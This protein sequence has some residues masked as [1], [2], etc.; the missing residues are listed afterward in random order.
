MI[1]ARNVGEAARGALTLPKRSSAVPV[2]DQWLSRDE[3]LSQLAACCE[4]ESVQLQRIPDNLLVQLN[5]LSG[6]WQK[7]FRLKSGL[8]YGKIH[9]FLLDD[10]PINLKAS[11]RKLGYRPDS[12]TQSLR[13]SVADAPESRS[14]KLVRDLVSS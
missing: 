1:S 13:E 9:Q 2:G 4:R 5:E 8:D 10:Q 6:F 12:I 11:Q 3:L 7:L 14:I